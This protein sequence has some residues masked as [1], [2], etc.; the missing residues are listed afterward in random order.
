[1]KVGVDYDFECRK[2][3]QCCRHYQYVELYDKDIERLVSLGFDPEEFLQVK[4][5]EAFLKHDGECVFLEGDLC[6]VHE[7]KPAVCR[8]YPLSLR[9]AREGR[10]VVCVECPGVELGGNSTLEFEEGLERTF[11][12]EEG[13]VVSP[14]L[15][16]EVR[17]KGAERI[18]KGE[19]PLESFPEVAWLMKES[20]RYSRKAGRREI[21]EQFWVS[22]LLNL[23][24][25]SF[26]E[27]VETK[28]PSVGG[29]EKEMEKRELA[30]IVE[31]LKVPLGDLPIYAEVMKRAVEKLARERGSRSAVSTVRANRLGIKQFALKLLRKSLY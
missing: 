6:R 24:A 25:N 27:G 9:E 7:A 18:E 2:C 16:R 22:P 29:R 11:P 1:M 28:V 30:G 20:G 17:K 3:G 8:A 12:L 19:R 14:K 5:G 10:T 4:G 21:R 13:R 15:A 31:R 26:I 23:L